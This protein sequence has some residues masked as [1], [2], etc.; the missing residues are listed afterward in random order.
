[1]T[2]TQNKM[3]YSNTQ[4]QYKIDHK[5]KPPGSL[6]RLEEIA[7]Q[8]G[9]IQESL[10]PRINRPHILVF[11]G[12]HGIAATGL[13]NP[14]PQAVTAQMVLNFIN[15]GAAINVFCRQH[16]IGL[17]IIDAGVNAKFEN[18][19]SPQFISSKIGFG[20]KNYLKE[21]AMSGD[22]V[23]ESMEKGKDIIARVRADGC[24]CVGFGEMGIGNTSAAALIM[25]AITG[26]HVEECVGKGTGVNREQMEQKIKTLQTVYNKHINSM[27]RPPSPLEVLQTFGGFEIAMMTGA[28]IEA[29]KRKMVIVV[30]GFI[31][32]AALLIANLMHATVSDHCIF[33]HTSEEK[34]HEK[35]LH[36]LNARPLL[37]LQMRLGEGTGAALAIPL[38]Q[39]A[40]KFVEEMASFEAAGVSNRE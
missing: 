28:Y 31:C 40:V 6:G 15:G 33:A 25:S 24:N 16:N 20:T 8:V 17:F 10:N 37:N 26:L 30:D 5:T 9:A 14:Y 13:V 1:M 11:A 38:I 23:R 39:S 4:L 27:S 22:E 29:A 34:G 35:M 3:P 21:P 19:S 32:T 18:I 7:L 12:D 36:Y 2:K